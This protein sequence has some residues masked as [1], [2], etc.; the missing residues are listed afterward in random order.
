MTILGGIEDQISLYIWGEISNKLYAISDPTLAN[1]YVYKRVFKSLTSPLRSSQPLL[2]GIYSPL[3][4]LFGGKFINIF[5]VLTFLLILAVSYL[6]FKK[7]RYPLI[8]GLLFAFS[9]YFMTHLGRHAALTQIWL[10]PLFFLLLKK[11]DGT[12]KNKLLLSLV[13]S[14]SILISNYLGFFLFLTFTVYL[15]SKVIVE[16][17]NRKKLLHEFKNALIIAIISVVFLSPFV[18]P[19]IKAIYLPNTKTPQ[20]IVVRKRN[21]SDFAAFSSRPWYFFIPPVKNPIFGSFSKS[22]LAKIESTG[23]FLADDYFASEHQENYFGLYFL[24]SFSFLFFNLNKKLDQ[25]SKKEI[26][27]NL[28][29]S[30]FI[31]SFMMPPFFTISGIKIF[32]PNWLI[33]K[34]FP[35]FRVTARLSIIVHFLLLVTYAK[36]ITFAAKENVIK[37]L[38]LN[39]LMLTLLFFTLVET[40]I[41]P[42]LY[43]IGTV[44]EVFAYLKNTGEHRIIAVYP[45][46]KADD[47]FFWVPHHQQLLINPRGFR[48]ENYESEALTKNLPSEE[49]LSM[50]S[51]LEVSHLVVYKEGENLDYFRLSEQLELEKEFEDSLL[52]KIK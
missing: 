28:L 36:L 35:I 7:Y 34:F 13:L 4:T 51:K 5:F 48:D 45:Y 10:V 41:P 24:L 42:K 47:A 15:L 17:F 20:Q 3:A 8:F 38:Y 49:G 37:K 9:T 27:I 46:S 14:S 16:K 52:Y 12:L 21:L 40:F 11:R 50:L 26:Y 30:V 6:Y 33:Y 39:I 22:L 43:D 18:F 31:I 19:Y 29:T 32:T 44:P 2:W 25:E 1:F 23:Y